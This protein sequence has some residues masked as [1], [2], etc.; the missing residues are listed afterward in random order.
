MSLEVGGPRLGG[1]SSRRVIFGDPAYLS[2]IFSATGFVE[3]RFLFI[4]VV[5]MIIPFLGGN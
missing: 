3:T 2:D 5:E 1:R 4:V